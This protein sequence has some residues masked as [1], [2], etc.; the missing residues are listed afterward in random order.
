MQPSSRETRPPAITA[1]AKYWRSILADEDLAGQKSDGAPVR[2]TV[3]VMRAGRLDEDMVKILQAE[4]DRFKKSAGRDRT[5][6]E[7]TFSE[8]R[9]VPVLIFAGGFSATRSHGAQYHVGSGALDH[10]TL[11]IPAMLDDG[12]VLSPISGAPPWIGRDHL[13]PNEQIDETVPVIGTLDDFDRWLTE[14][15]LPEES[16]QALIAW[17]DGLWQQVVGNEGPA[18]FTAIREV[19]VDLGKSLQNAGRHLGQLY[20]ALQSQKRFPV[21]FERLCRGSESSMVVGPRLRT[22]KLATPRGTM[23]TAYGLAN[24]QADVIAAFTDLA[25]GGILAVNGPPGTGKT[26]LLQSIIATEVVNRALAGADPA[27]IV[28]TSTNNQA[29]TNIIASLNGILTENPAAA[30]HPWAMRWLPNIDTY[31]L[32]MPAGGDRA[33]TAARQGIATAHRDRA[34]ANR[35]TGFPD[36]ES[37][38]AY[39]AKARTEWLERCGA[40]YGLAEVTLADGLDRL[41][42]D[43]KSI[44][45]ELADFQDLLEKR[46]DIEEWWRAEAG[47]LAP[48]DFIAEQDASLAQ[49][50]DEARNRLEQAEREAW[51]AK[52]ALSRASTESAD[53]DKRTAETIADRQRGY[54]EI[55]AKIDAALAPHGLMETLLGAI[56]GLR[57][58]TAPKRLARLTALSA[59]E[60]RIGDLFAQLPGNA[61]A[62]AWISQAATA[63]ADLSRDLSR[64]RETLAAAARERA[65]EIARLDTALRHAEA[66]R[67]AATQALQ[68]AETSRQDRMAFLESQVDDLHFC[69]EML[70]GAVAGLCDAATAVYGVAARTLPDPQADLSLVELDQLLDV[71]LRHMA[72]QKAMR[73]W[74]GRWLIEAEGVQNGSINVRGGQQGM[75]ARFRRWCMLT[76]CLIVT[77]HSLPRHF[78]ALRKADNGFVHDF[79]FDFI[80]LLIIDEAGQV[81]PHIGAAAFALARRAVV[82]G[83]IYQIEPVVQV[84]R[85]ADLGNCA[86]LGLSSLWVDGEPASPLLV[87]EPSDGSPQGSIMRLAQLAS[88][89]VSPAT[90]KEPGILLTEHR[91]CRAEIVEFCNRLVYHGQLQPMSPPRRVPPPLPPLAWAHV[92]GSPRK[93]GGSRDNRSEAKAIAGWIASNAGQWCAQSCYGRPIEEIVAVV[94]P[95]RPQAQQI[96]AAL[97]AANRQFE[98]ITV[99]TVHSLQG[100]ERPIVVFSP[101][102]GAQ[103]GGALFFDRKPN[104]LNVAVSRAKDSFVVIGDMRLFR[105]KTKSPSSVLGDLLFVDDLHELSDVDGNHHFSET[106]LAAGERISTL[107]RHREVL[108]QAFDRIGSGQTLLIASPWI[109]AR[110]IHDDGLADAVAGAV[111][112]RGAVVEIFYDRELASRTPGHRADEAIAA[113]RDAGAVLRPVNRMHNKTVIVGRS[114]IIEGSFNWLSAV[115][116]RDAAYA[117]HETSWR[118]TGSTA[119]E[120]IDT[121]LAEFAALVDSAN[122]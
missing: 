46:S 99:G 4:W 118:I 47:P 59:Q 87:S 78:R 74:E 50:A 80:D 58:A 19:R 96:K 2:T 119:A 104:M 54:F 83:D 39:L 5:E 64:H 84:S 79:M 55:K 44:V 3:E 75:E 103:D 32:F 40:E 88:S 86:R 25:D 117:R 52:D 26:T 95:F 105:R 115:R 116:M 18:G 65:A 85:G 82:V 121:A 70:R 14:N 29:V 114:E 12:G 9:H 76:P 111:Q 77:L 73:Y 67:E 106:M 23:S 98:K 97:K 93:I 71:T 34:N 68:Q 60:A 15:P 92:Q 31:G 94:T 91:R 45:H 41:R 10:F 120:A 35:W 102:Y 22:L 49:A 21:L 38:P 27:V 1:L 42:D 11:H 108:R 53:A 48:A 30:T 37:D 89:A 13:A 113:L 122:R 6:D 112:G 16:W 81:S 72:F 109:T 24:S 101:T 66:V 69:R 36:K 56:P 33:A 43:L 51:Q 17:I 28:G 61:T 90:E 20:E 63:L 7:N 110:A 57:G 8:S 62:A 107:D 100:A